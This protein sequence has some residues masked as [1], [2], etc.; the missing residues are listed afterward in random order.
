LIC[1]EG[2]ATLD[3][4]PDFDRTVW[5]NVLELHWL[6]LLPSFPYHH[7]HSNLVES[8]DVDV[9]SIWGW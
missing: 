6:L 4:V 8:K 5:Q 7:I 1:G 2:G 9:V 3:L